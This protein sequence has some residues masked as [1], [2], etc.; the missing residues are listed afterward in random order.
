[1]RRCRWALFFKYILDPEKRTL[2]N[3]ILKREEGIAMAAT[4]MLEISHNEEERARMES[5]LKRMLDARSMALTFREVGMG[6]RAIRGAGGKDLG[7]RARY[8][9]GGCG[10]GLYQPRD[11][12]FQGRTGPAVC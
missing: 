9:C 11:W 3:G 10:F 1:V 2:I 7:N 5:E 6:G 8:A 12:A 4:T